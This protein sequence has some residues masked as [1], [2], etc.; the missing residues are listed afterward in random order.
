MCRG[1]LIEAS[2]QAQERPTA[3]L[4]EQA[5]R[6]THLV[7]FC[8]IDNSLIIKNQNRAPPKPTMLIH[9][10][11]IEVTN[12]DNLAPDERIRK[13]RIGRVSGEVSH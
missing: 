11:I 6:R 3:P 2:R 8:R 5:A 12:V 9:L 13:L 1:P 10:I 4:D 7:V